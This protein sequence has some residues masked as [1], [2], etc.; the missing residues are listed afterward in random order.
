MASAPMREAPDADG[1]ADPDGLGEL[2]PDGE[3]L[4]PEPVGFAGALLPLVLLPLEEPVSLVELFPPDGEDELVELSL[5]GPFGPPVGGPDGGPD[6]LPEGLPVGLPEG[7]PVALP[8]G[9]ADS[10]GLGVSL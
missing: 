7:L 8:E 5:L 4:P 6:G 9:E 2:P 3:L 1:D 10:E